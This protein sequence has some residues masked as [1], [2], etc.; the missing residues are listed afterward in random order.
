VTY[1]EYVITLVVLTA[2]LA[3]LFVISIIRES[4]WG[5]AADDV[6]CVTI[7]AW[8]YFGRHPRR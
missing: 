1:K 4:I 6:L 5:M 8:T 7:L 2:I 3:A